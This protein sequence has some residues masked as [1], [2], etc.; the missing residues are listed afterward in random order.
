GAGDGLDGV[1][2]YARLQLRAE[3]VAEHITGC[4]ADAETWIVFHVDVGD[5]AKELSHIRPLRHFRP[6]ASAK[7]KSLPLRAAAVHLL[8][9]N[10]HRRQNPR[11]RPSSK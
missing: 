4:R 11:H 5:R 3:V 7:I 2:K 1:V 6:D 10:R 8:G 9:R